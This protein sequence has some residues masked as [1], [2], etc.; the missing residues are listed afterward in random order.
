[1]E[2]AERL[3]HFELPGDCLELELTESLVMANPEQSIRAL[4]ALAA[5]GVRIVVDDFGTGYSSLSYLK[6]L[7][8]KKLKIDKSFIRDIGH[9]PNDTTI[10][11]I[12][13]AL[14][15]VLELHAVAEGVETEEQLHFLQ[16]SGCD[17]AQG[18]LIC[19]P[20]PAIEIERFML[21]YGKPK[22]VVAE[23]L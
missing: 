21:E 20:L 7:P 23:A 6:K 11:N 12:V 1:V 15:H 3:R 13:I 17:E 19:R 5:Q 8:I 2:I 18:F 10:V 14:A 4:D 16:S 9:D 22:R